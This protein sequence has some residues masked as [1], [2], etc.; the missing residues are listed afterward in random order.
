MA[1][2]MIMLIMMMMGM[3]MMM[4]VMVTMVIIMIMHLPLSSHL[5]P[6]HMAGHVRLKQLGLPEYFH[7]ETISIDHC[8]PQ[9]FFCKF[10]SHA[11]L[12]STLSARNN[13]LFQTSPSHAQTEAFN[14]IVI[15]IQES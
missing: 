15:I 7:S 4:L 3:M 12:H 11:W 5:P 10:Q 9:F 6:H 1:L 13:F 8:F 2:M 14:D